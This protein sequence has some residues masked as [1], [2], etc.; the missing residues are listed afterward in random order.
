MLA[1]CICNF[2]DF[3]M[4]F[5]G[6]GK[7]SVNNEYDDEKPIQSNGINSKHHPEREILPPPPPRKNKVEP[8]EK[9][10]PPP[11]IPRVEEEDI[12]VGEG[13]QYSVPNKDMSESPPLSEDMEESPRK[14]RQSYFNEPVYGPVPPSEPAQTWEQ[15]VSCS[16][17]YYVYYLN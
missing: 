7:V 4:L 13:V 16:L 11:P 3:K 17:Q 2:I 15:T 14:E 8:K 9:Q 1:L 12:F 5:S 6:T 10:A